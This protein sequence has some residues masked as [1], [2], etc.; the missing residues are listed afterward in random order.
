MEALFCF[1]LFPWCV[2][3]NRVQGSF[4]YIRGNV[5]ALFS[6]FALVC[7]H[8]P[9]SRL[10]PAYPSPCAVVCNMGAR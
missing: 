8:N 4:R 5:E 9:R 2:S 10:I 3:I 6:F 1:V 7:H